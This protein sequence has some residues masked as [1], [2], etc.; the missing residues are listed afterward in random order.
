VKNML[1]TGGC[2]FIGTN[3][4]R[5][6]LEESNFAGRVINVDS[7]TYA[8]NPENLADIEA[9]FPERY[10]FKKCDICDREIMAGATLPPNLMLTGPLLSLMPL[11]IQTSWV[12]LLCW[13]W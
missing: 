9:N 8:A 5:Y 6:L 12:R 10:V 4:I 13:S 3:F 2:G 11:S 1:V 7:L